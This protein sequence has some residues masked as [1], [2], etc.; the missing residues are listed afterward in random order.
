MA[1]VTGVAG[2]VLPFDAYKPTAAQRAL[3][4]DAHA[5]L[6]AQ[7]MRRHGFAVSP[8]PADAAV[9]AA[10]DPG[11]SRRYGIADLARARR[12]GYH[13]AR[14]ATAGTAWDDRLS[15]AARHRLYGSSGRP[16]CVGRASAM[17]G[18]GA[19]KADWRWLALQ[20]SRTLDQAADQPAVT[21]AAGRW[22]ACM[23]RAGLRYPTPEAAIADRRWNLEQATVTAREKR[24]A[25]ADT[26]CKWSS[27]LVAAWFAADAAL[28]RAVIA[29]EPDRFAMLR[30]N[31]RHR[32]AR[33]SAAAGR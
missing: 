25:T 7:C 23:E 33:A 31:L 13:L 10:T 11:N 4:A 20:D 15:Q 27:G 17:I 2:L 28:Q 5:G 8:P 30:A 9:I 32:L 16:G 1:Q 6:L 19:P 3:L 24:T 14:S 22:K 21:E 18:G 29:A 12:Y 26:A